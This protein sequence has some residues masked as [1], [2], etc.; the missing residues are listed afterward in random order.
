MEGSFSFN[1]RGN[2]LHGQLQEQNQRKRPPAKAKSFDIWSLVT[3]PPFT[4]SLVD[5]VMILGKQLC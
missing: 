4:A 1:W 2:V 5:L 3:I